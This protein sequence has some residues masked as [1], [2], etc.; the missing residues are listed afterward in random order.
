MSW[1]H[2]GSAGGT[3]GLV[4]SPYNVPAV[5]PLAYLTTELTYMGSANAER[6]FLV[7]G[8]RACRCMARSYLLSMVVIFYLDKSHAFIGGGFKL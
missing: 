5:Q 1:G 4:M 2:G 3:V 8:G 7:P 6:S